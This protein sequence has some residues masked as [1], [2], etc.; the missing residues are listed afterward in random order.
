ML[1]T[2]LVHKKIIFI[3]LH[4]KQSKR[5]KMHKQEIQSIDDNV[6]ENFIS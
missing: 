5:M 6:F 2:I 4:L 3:S 1:S